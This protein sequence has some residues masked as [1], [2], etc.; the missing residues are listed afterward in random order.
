MNHDLSCVKWLLNEIVSCTNRNNLVKQKA[1]GSSGVN[2]EKLR[3]Y[4]G[5]Q[6]PE[7]EN[8]RGKEER[9]E[10]AM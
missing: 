3:D 8:D 5:A 4:L 6:C 10:I 7:R 1:D 9:R 2:F